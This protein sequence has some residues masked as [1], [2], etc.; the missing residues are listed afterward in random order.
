MQS[1]TNQ[2]KERTKSRW[3]IELLLTC[4]SFMSPLGSLSK[5]VAAAA[6]ASR[7]LVPLIGLGMRGGERLFFFLSK[8]G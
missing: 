7:T 6:T 3:S 2:T 8:F 1:E 5:D 4:A